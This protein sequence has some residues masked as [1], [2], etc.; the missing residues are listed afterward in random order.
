MKRSIAIASSTRLPRTSSRMMRSFF[1]AICALRAND[2]GDHRY[3]FL[4]W[5][6]WAER[7]VCP[8]NV[9]VGANSPSL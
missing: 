7:L 2:H 9:R 5:L 1:G 4:T 3:F 8:R 6:T